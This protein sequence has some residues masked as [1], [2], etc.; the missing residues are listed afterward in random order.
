MYK[1]GKELATRVEYRSPDPACNPYLAFS[2]MLAAGLEGIEKEYPLRDP[3]ERNCYEMT[4]E[5]RKKYK[6]ESLPEDLYEAI[7]VTEK[8]DMV[9]RAL[10]DHVFTKFIENKMIEWERYR[11]RVTDYELEQYFSIL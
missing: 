9:R 4:K 6:I 3:V 7:Q 2:V 5:E 10:G 8:S 1:P 11:A